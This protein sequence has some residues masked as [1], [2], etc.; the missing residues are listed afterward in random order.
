MTDWLEINDMIYNLVDANTGW[1]NGERPKINQYMINFSHQKL[2]GGDQEG[3]DKLKSDVLSFLRTGATIAAERDQLLKV[4][5][6]YL[7]T[8]PTGS[9]LSAS[10]TVQDGIDYFKAL[11]KELDALKADN[12]EL[13][14]ALKLSKRK[15]SA[16]IG[17][18]DGDK[19]LTEAIIPLANKAI[20]KAEGKL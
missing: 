18:C 20:A 19:E 1:E 13:L 7:A 9:V 5:G 17:V 15:L 4:V 11:H 14:E 8:I 10:A 2:A 6:S 16:Y 12:A 3:Q